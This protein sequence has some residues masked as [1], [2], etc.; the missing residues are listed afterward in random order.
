LNNNTLSVGNVFISFP[1]NFSTACGEDCPDSVELH[2]SVFNATA[3]HLS[4]IDSPVPV[5][6]ATDIAVTS[7]IV[8]LGVADLESGVLCEEPDCTLT[9]EVPVS[10]Y[11]ASKITACMRID[12]ATAV[13]LDEVS[14]ISFQTGS[15]SSNNQSV[16]CEVSTLGD[17]FVVEFTDPSVFLDATVRSIQQDSEDDTPEQVVTAEMRFADL[18]YNDYEADPTLADVLKSRIEQLMT[19]ASTIEGAIYE[20]VEL[21]PGSVIAI[22]N[23]TLPAD[24][25]QTV[26][27][28]MI[29]VIQTNPAELFDSDFIDDYGAPTLTVTQAPGMEAP[30]PIEED[31]NDD[32]MMIVIIAASIVGAIV[33]GSLA[34]FLC[35][36]AFGKSTAS[37]H[38]V[39]GNSY[40]D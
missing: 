4:F 8:S 40:L 3:L 16:L 24:S 9:V 27:D 37:Y 1:S 7:H 15:Y 19:E 33:L 10:S 20:V 25:N 17:L 35:V 23:I 34:L 28:A 13:G 14:G 39:H 22:V 2:A 21:R 30:N 36:K 26:I 29:D 5:V 38:D 18:N 31:D 11:N 6:G 12:G 32:K